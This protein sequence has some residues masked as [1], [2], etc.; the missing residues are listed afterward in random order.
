MSDRDCDNGCTT[1]LRFPR[2]PGTGPITDHQAGCPCCASSRDGVSMDNRPALSR[3]NYRIGTYG[4]IREFLLH[5]MDR[6]PALQSW[7]HRG[8]DDPA[9][10]LVE[11]AAILGDILTFYQE[12][13]A[14]EAFLRTA[15]WN[16]SI[17]ELV[18]LLGYRLSPALGGRGIFAFQFKKNE[19]IAIPA[20]VP[21]KVTLEG[22]AKPSEF[23]TTEALTALPWLNQ[24][25]LYR[26][27]EDGEI[28][29]QTIEF[30]IAAPEQLLH[31]VVL[32]P[33]ER[34]MIGDS[35][36]AWPGQ[37]PELTNAEI[38][39]VDS[40]RELHGT[41]IIKI[42]GN[43]TRLSNAGSLTAYR[44]GRTFHHF[45]HNGPGQILDPDEPLIS[46]ASVL[47]GTETNETETSSLI[48]YLDVPSSRPINR[49]SG[50]FSEKAISRSIRLDQLPLDLELT[51]LPP[52]R[53]VV[54]Q[55]RFRHPF[56]G[57]A[58]QMFEPLPPLRTLVRTI[59]HVGTTTLTWGAVNGTV[60]EITVE[61]PI[62]DSIGD[63]DPVARGLA[64]NALATAN[65]E[66]TS[67]ESALT[68]VRHNA[69][70]VRETADDLAAASIRADAEL[71]AAQGRT[72][73]ARTVAATMATAA[74]VAAAALKDDATDLATQTA[75]DDS[76]VALGAANDAKARIATAAGNANT[77]QTDARTAKT[78]A[79]A[80]G[81]A[82]IAITA[83]LV[84]PMPGSL[85]LAVDPLLGVL[86]AAVDVTVA[87]SVAAANTAKT[88]VETA[89]ATVDIAKTAVDLAQ[90]KV[91]LANVSAAAARTAA[92]VDARAVARSALADSARNQANT[93]VGL[94]VAAETTATTAADLAARNAASAEDAAMAAADLIRPALERVMRARAAAE[95]KRIVSETRMYIKDALFHEVTSPLLV[96]TR[97]KLETTLQN[98][99]TLNFKGTAAEAASLSGRRVM[100]GL[101]D[102]QPLVTTVASVPSTLDPL[103]D[104][105][106]ILRPVVLSSDVAYPDFANEHPVVDVFGNLVNATEGKT[107]AEIAIGSG[108]AGQAFQTVKLPKPPLTYHLVAGNTPSATPRIAVYVDGRE[109]RQV[110]TFFDRGAGEPL[111]IVREDADGTSWVQFGDGK[112]GARLTNGVNNVTAVYRT[113]AGAFGELKDGTK[114]QAGATLKNLDKI[115]MPAD[116]TGGAPAEA[117][118]N[119]RYAA[120]GRVQSLGRL[121]SL[122]DFESEAAAI[123]GVAVASAS[124]QLV[125][126]IPAVEVVVLMDTGRADELQA[127]AETLNAF[128]LQRGAGRDP[129]SV[130]GGRR[131]HVTAAVEYAL[132]PSFRADVVERAIRKALGV[133]D[134]GAT[135][136]APDSGLFSVSQRRFGEREYASR[137]AGRV[138]N[139]DGVRW[140][141][142]VGFTALADSDDPAAIAQPS[143]TA[144]EPIVGCDHR[145]ILSLFDGHLSLRAVLEGER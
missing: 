71:L 76:N 65:Q 84:P 61:G 126:G 69:R 83:H 67:A 27:L 60:S 111:Y 128:N 104:P 109:W 79:D 117:A 7:T 142:T 119:A 43:L 49:P 37:P 45:G 130:T 1:P 124:W 24:F 107:L 63:G 108:D 82:A 17:A 3:F 113:G 32:Q 48:P 75:L 86:V 131:L 29:P 35:A 23:E 62:Y 31:P 134:G 93:A 98:G 132:D 46:H 39:I 58:S 2:R 90:E 30:S 96:M 10:A 144:L 97:A 95:S 26:P 52:E 15:Q 77:A 127:V 105:F 101:P 89:K 143:S 103:L 94:A 40:V 106:S 116:I 57:E 100:L 88:S 53:P 56:A 18:R 54:M 99:S 12:T 136:I 5:G 110:D 41:K 115:V 19:A 16:D 87:T 123:P 140:A 138:Q 114:V 129:V 91:R 11:G 44:I 125:D 36:Q 9:V 141:R 68:Q 33:G 80:A 42:A 34:L 118:D 121:V 74:E 72:A 59:T 73:T 112:N 137:I 50:S 139:V 135:P 70:V 78:Q 92:R 64:A 102:R 38:V 85:H 20:G 8:A 133:N 25:H 14:N 66:V 6:S 51:D 81:V 4:S 120:P 122:R 145:H 13:Y 21:L 22:F 47:R 55:A 28:T